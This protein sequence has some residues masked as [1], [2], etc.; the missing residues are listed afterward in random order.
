MKNIKQYLINL[1]KIIVKNLL[2]TAGLGLCIF[3]IQLIKALNVYNGFAIGIIFINYLILIFILT[4]IIDLIKITATTNKRHF[5]RSVLL[6]IS[7]IITGLVLSIKMYDFSYAFI[8][9]AFMTF[10][11]FVLPFFVTD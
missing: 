3:G 7:V 4:T 6:L 11:S 2:V 9:L 8:T 5:I 10:V 1:A